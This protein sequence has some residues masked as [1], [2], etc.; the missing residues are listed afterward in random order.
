MGEVGT[1]TGDD[2]AIRST[3]AG[4][5]RGAKDD[6]IANIDFLISGR[7]KKSLL[8]IA[9][10]W[11]GLILASCSQSDVTLILSQFQGGDFQ[12]AE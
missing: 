5:F 2:V 11:P 6:H 4:D 10:T 9:A 7:L 1:G 12:P 8:K 3:I